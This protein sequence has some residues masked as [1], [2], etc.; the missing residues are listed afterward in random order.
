MRCDHFYG[1]EIS[2]GDRDELAADPDLAAA[3]ATLGF[4]LK[5]SSQPSLQACFQ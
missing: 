3:T 4:R 2:A 1:P 5:T